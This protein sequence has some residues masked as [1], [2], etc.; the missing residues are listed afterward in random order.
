MRTIVEPKEH[1]AKL[2]GK[3]KVHEEAT[4]RLMRYV[5]RVDHDDKVLLHNVVTGQL[6]VLDQVETEALYM[7]PKIYSPVME[8]L[9]SDHFLVPEAYDEHQQVINLR[10]IHRLLDEANSTKEIIGYTIL[11]TTACNARCY[12]CFEQ[13]VKQM[14]MTEETANDLVEF[15]SNH[16][17][18]NKLLELVWFG[19]EPTVAAT[20]IDQIC[21]GLQ[22][23]DISFRSKMITNGYLFDEE[24]V[25]K[26]KN[27]WHLWGLQICV[28]G[29]E[30]SYNRIKAFVGAKDNPYQRIMHNIGL[31]L[32]NGIAV[33]LRMNYD[34][35]NYDE[36]KSVVDEAYERFGNNPLLSVT[37]H[38]VIGE[39]K[40]LN[41][42]IHHGDDAWFT[43]REI[44]M[45]DIAY[46]KGYIRRERS[47][48]FLNYSKCTAGNEASVT[49]RP[50]GGI[51]RCPQLFGDDQL[52][53]T[54]KKGIIN[55][56]IIQSWK[57]SV[58]AEVCWDCTLYANCNRLVRCPDSVY[59]HKAPTYKKRFARMIEEIYDSTM[60]AEA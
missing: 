25:A 60:S 27:L 6:V 43:Q 17:G 11:P 56:D 57:Q 22:D 4:F 24:M 55:R 36:F 7:L 19:G 16:C 34:V 51:V 52:T 33:G 49:V 5:L 23:K 40:D 9:V 12:Y 15:M 44:E 28:D 32:E 38:P 8:A 41:G 50:D 13:G 18:E 45:D 10:R 39:H 53:G 3:Q 2:W 29:T 37:A 21:Q 48:P 35:G 59:C 42:E 14:T 58:D 47:L 1:I 20:R 46:R 26:A 31:L 30:E 54:V